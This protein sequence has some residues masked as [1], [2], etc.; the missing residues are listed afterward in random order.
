MLHPRILRGLSSASALAD[1]SFDAF[2]VRR[3]HKEEGFGSFRRALYGWSIVKVAL[4]DVRPCHVEGRSSLRT[5]P[6]R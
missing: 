3:R 1:L 5:G 6:A 4:E 2:L